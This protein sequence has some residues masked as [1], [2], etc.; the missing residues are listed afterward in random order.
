MYDSFSNSVQPNTG[1]TF[2]TLSFLVITLTIEL[3]RV[4]VFSMILMHVKCFCA[5]FSEHLFILRVWLGWQQYYQWWFPGSGPSVSEQGKAASVWQPDMVENCIGVIFGRMVS[6]SVFQQRFL[7]LLL[8]CEFKSLSR[9]MFEQKLQNWCCQW[10]VH[11]L[12]L[13]EG[14]GEIGFNP[15]L[16]HQ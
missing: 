2:V 3:L 13:W 1:V 12:P 5:V 6:M 9:L 14:E 15:H 8:E 16:S 10:A 11:P 4:F 7:S